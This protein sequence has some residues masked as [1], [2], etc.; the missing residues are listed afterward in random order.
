MIPFLRETL[1]PLVKIIL[2]FLKKD[3]TADKGRVG[4][5]PWW[6]RFGD[7]FRVVGNKLNKKR[8]WITEVK[9]ET[10]K[11]DMAKRLGKGKT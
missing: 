3:I 11:Q 4:E 7:S 10:I 5:H 8:D 6:E 2:F 9:N 1:K